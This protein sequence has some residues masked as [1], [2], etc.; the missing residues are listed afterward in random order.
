VIGDPCPTFSWGSVEGAKSYELVIYRLREEGE[1]ARPV[2]RQT[3]AGS[4]ASWTP[5]LDRCLERGGQYAW[6][7]RATGGGEASEWSSP[8]LFEVV[9]GPSEA[10]FEVAV[11]VVRSYLAAQDG[12]ASGAGKVAEAEPAAEPDSRPPASAG[13]PFPRGVTPPT[14]LEV[15]GTLACIGL[16]MNS[17]ALAHKVLEIGDWNMNATAAV[18]VPHGLGADFKRIRSVTGIVR[19]DDDAAYAVIGTSNTGADMD[20]FFKHNNGGTFGIDNTNI[21]IQRLAGGQ[22][23]ADAIWNDTGFNRGW[24]TIWYEP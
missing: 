16:R 13:V 18:V 12:S 22:M 7:V 20:V 21:R 9:S 2:L 11:A 17:V 15:D 24:V 6:S 14:L 4:V 3:F 5:S 8:T 23:G 1:E 19:N 10:E